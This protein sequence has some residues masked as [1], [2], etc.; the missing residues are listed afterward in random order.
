[1]LPRQAVVHVATMLAVADLDRSVALYR[2][3]LGF[4]VREEVP[5]LALLG[6]GPMLL[7]LVTDCPPTP[8]KPGV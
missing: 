7:Y 2:D 1:M 5:G 6:H 4:E 8:D 3:R